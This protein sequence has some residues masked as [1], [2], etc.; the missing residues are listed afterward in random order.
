MSTKNKFN[1][2]AGV[3]DVIPKENND[4]LGGAAGAYVGVVGIADSKAEFA[5]NVRAAFLAMG[6]DL[7]DLDEVEEIDSR[8]LWSNA[9][10]S[11]REKLSALSATN[12][13]ECGVFHSYSD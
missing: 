1:Y 7:L 8:E 12:P 4:M 13:L 6:F 5:S 9:D 10:P 11:M 3:A 2:W